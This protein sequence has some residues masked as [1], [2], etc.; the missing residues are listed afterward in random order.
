[1]ASVFKKDKNKRGAPYYI[2]WNDHTG[3]RRTMCS[4]TS[5]KAT[6]MRIASKREA[7]A[8]SRREGVIDARL[9]AISNE[10][11][12]P[13][14]SHLADYESK[15]Q[16]ASRIA[17]LGSGDDGPICDHHQLSVALL[18]QAIPDCGCTR[19]DTKDSHL[20][21]PQTAVQ[22]LVCRQGHHGVFA[23]LQ[24]IVDVLHVVQILH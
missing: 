20:N 8:A 23:N 6:A 13:V 5:D 14:E 15:L 17:I 10:S 12:R 1:M 2:Q 4:K 24:R 18:D 16:A 3:K 7:E 19:V 11:K 22:V 21:Y 9:E